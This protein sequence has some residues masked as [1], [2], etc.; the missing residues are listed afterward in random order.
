MGMMTRRAWLLPALALPLG[1]TAPWILTANLS[2]LPPG[3]DAPSTEGTDADGHP[4]GIASQRGKVVML[5]FWSSGCGPC[6]RMFPHE[7]E[8]V[9]KYAS[10]PFVLLGVNADPNPH[11]LRQTQQRAQLRWPSLWDGPGGGICNAWKVQA[12]PTIVLI[13]QAGKVRFRHEGMAAQST[14]EGHIT[15]LL[16]EGSPPPKGALTARPGAPA[17]G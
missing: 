9:A 10:S 1:C 11:Q 13:D 7:N 15:G 8:L 14:L 6:R 17:P 3:E 2:R 4:L 5:S 12:F 16:A